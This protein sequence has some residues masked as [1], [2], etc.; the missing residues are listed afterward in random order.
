[1]TTETT[2]LP[3]YDP[4]RLVNKTFKQLLNETGG[5]AAGYSAISNWLACPEKSRLQSVGI[6][7]RPFSTEGD[8]LSALTFGSLLHF[9]REARIQFGPDFAE[10]LLDS[11]RPELP[12]ESF[13]KA[14]MM[15]RVYENLFPRAQDTFEYL[16]VECEVVTDIGRALGLGTSILRTVRY[17]SVVRVPGIGGAPDE[18]FSFECKT[19]ARAGASSLSGY[20]TQAMVQYALWNANPNLVAQYGRMAGVIFDCLVKTATPNVERVGPT[21]FGRVH[22]KLAL[23][24]LALAND[25]SVVF[26]VQPDGTYPKMLHNCW[27][28]YSPCQYIPLC[29]EGAHSEFENR[30]GSPYE[31]P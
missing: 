24:Y 11:W 28:K 2:A 30:D 16:G 14:R 7:R 22:E 23:Q 29:H 20:T 9:L 13:A 12:A 21:Y 6:R 27:G 8:E 15:M 17:D 26:K 18:L 3:K 4:T 10:Q 19:M 31:G 25:G 1:M 5:S